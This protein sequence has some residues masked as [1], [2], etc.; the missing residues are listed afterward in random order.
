MGCRM[1]TKGKG[2]RGQAVFGSLITTV[3]LIP[4]ICEL[5]PNVDS[6]HTSDESIN[7]HLC[8]S[9]IPCLACPNW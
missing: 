2:G 1:T 6:E 4:L 5:F 7:H 3:Q 9:P 8:P